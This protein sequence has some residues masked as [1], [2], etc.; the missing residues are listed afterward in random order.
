M[1]RSQMEREA[2]QAEGRM[3][4][5]P[6]AT[7]L[8]GAADIVDALRSANPDADNEEILDIAQTTV[9]EYGGGDSLY[10]AV[11]RLVAEETVCPLCRRCEAS[12]DSHGFCSTCWDFGFELRAA[13]AIAKFESKARAARM[14]RPIVMVTSLAARGPCRRRTFRTLTPAAVV[15]AVREAGPLTG[16]ALRDLLREYGYRC[17]NWDFR[18]AV[19]AAEE[20]GVTPRYKTKDNGPRFR[21][22]V[23][24]TTYVFEDR[25]AR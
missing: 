2:R 16:T 4:E 12:A 15:Q 22:T 19:G 7:G 6:P 17:G 18:D 23:I 13:D 3:P 21:P 20:W 25:S 14:A 10:D 8:L 11:C 24:S 5:P 1:K 9:A